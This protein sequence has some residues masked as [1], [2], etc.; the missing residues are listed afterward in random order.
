[1]IE[2]SKGGEI[3]IGIVKVIAYILIAILVMLWLLRWYLVF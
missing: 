3:I 2:R 1:M